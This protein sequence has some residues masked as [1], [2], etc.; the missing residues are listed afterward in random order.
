MPA[1]QCQSA[2]LPG[3]RQTS[4]LSN[5]HKQIAGGET[6]SL[7]PHL[8]L[9]L[10]AGTGRQA[11]TVTG[12]GGPNPW[13]EHPMHRKERYINGTLSPSFPLSLSLSLLTTKHAT[14]LRLDNS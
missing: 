4:D 8:A 12:M 5:K 2:L 1:P 6:H 9:L 10:L 11:D 7:Q 3:Q 14:T 13:G